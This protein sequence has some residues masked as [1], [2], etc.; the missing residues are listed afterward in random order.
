MVNHSVCIMQTRQQTTRPYVWEMRKRA[1]AGCGIPKPKSSSLREQQTDP[2]QQ[3][4][5]SRMSDD[6]LTVDEFSITAT[7]QYPSFLAAGVVAQLLRVLEPSPGMDP[8]AV[9]TLRLQKNSSNYCN[10][11]VRWR[12]S[13]LW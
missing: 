11:S 1:P 8:L 5:P 2:R 10:G 13:S 9:W 7:T 3:R 4:T 12:C 6:S